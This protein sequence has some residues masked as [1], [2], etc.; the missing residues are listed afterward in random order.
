MTGQP[1]GEV[2]AADLVDV[3]ELGVAVGVLLPLQGLGVG[4]QA[5]AE[6]VEQLADDAVA[7]GE[8]LLARASASWRVLLQV[9]RSGD[10]GSPRVSGAINSSR[11]S[12]IAGLLSRTFLRPSAE[13]PDV[14]GGR[15]RSVELLQRPLDRRMGD[16]RGPAHATDAAVAERAGL[17]GGEEPPLPLI[18]VRQDRGELALQF[19][20]VVHRVIMCDDEKL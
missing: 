9:H 18:E 12:R 4:L 3:A 20:V 14:T 16:A 17:G 19:R 10:I 6:V 5:V 8:P 1:R 7:D 2:S 13:A 11:A 15:G